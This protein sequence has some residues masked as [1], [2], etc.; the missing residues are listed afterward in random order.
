MLVQV[1]NGDKGLNELLISDSDHKWLNGT[2]DNSDYHFI[3]FNIQLY[4]L[5]LNNRL[6]AWIDILRSDQCY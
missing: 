5:S 1:N 3:A 6:I 2:A 4:Q